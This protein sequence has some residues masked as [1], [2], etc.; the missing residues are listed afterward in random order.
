MTFGSILLVVENILFENILHLIVIFLFISRDEM[1]ISLSLSNKIVIHFSVKF[2][3]KL[4]SRTKNS[5]NI[6]ILNLDKDSKSILWPK[7]I[8]SFIYEPI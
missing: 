5:G 7:F 1:F 2:S 6:F 3:F 8:D 4:I